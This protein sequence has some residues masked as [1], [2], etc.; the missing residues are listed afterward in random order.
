MKWIR[1]FLC[2]S[3]LIIAT[4]TLGWSAKDAV[5]ASEPHERQSSQPPPAARMVD[6][7]APDGTALKANYF[8]A[9]KPGPGVLLFHQSNRTRKSWD[10]VAAQ[11]AAAGINTLTID[12]RGFGQ[13]GGKE[14]EKLTSAEVA[15][16][17]YEVWPGD[18]DVA[19]QYLVSQTG[20]KHDVIGLGGAGY[21]GVDNSVQTARRHASDVKSLALLSG[22]TF[23]PGLR[24]L[25]QASQLPGMF[26]VADDD[27]YPPTAEAMELLYSM[28]SYLGKKF[29]HYAGKRAPWLGDENKAGVPATGSHGTDLFKVHPELP[30]LI[31]DWFVT[32]LIKTPGHAPV[33]NSGAAA[34]PFASIINQL[35]IPGGVAQIT[36]QLMEARRRDPKAQLW[37]EYV[38]S[39]LGYDHLRVGDTKSAV[40]I[41]KLNILAYPE[42]ANASDSLSDVY[43]ADGQKDLARQYAEKALVLLASDTNDSEAWRHVIRE[44]AQQKL[45]KLGAAP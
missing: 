24:F 4:S 33:D 13:S 39:I 2:M 31:V 19:W 8:G 22:E 20:V 42:S 21:D 43:L 14:Y 44:S 9:A 5:T 15:H 36:Q 27:E 1:V 16:E 32:T 29:V 28:S 35:Q 17:R 3:S 18:I 41:M 45:K 37:P 25:R 26:V 11:L 34:L 38:V 6:L 12:M 7:K 30:G 10:A 40:E 23:L